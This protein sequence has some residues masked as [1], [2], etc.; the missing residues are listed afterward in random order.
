MSSFY[1][2]VTPEVAERIMDWAEQN[3]VEYDIW[4]AE[5][6][7]LGDPLVEIGLEEWPEEFD[8]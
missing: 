4:N 3:N 8:N 2:K 1:R 7:F 6:L 5:E